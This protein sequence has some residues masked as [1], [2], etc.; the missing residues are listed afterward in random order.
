MALLIHR[1]ISWRRWHQT[2]GITACLGL[3]LWSV[4]GLSHPL[5][6]RVQPQPATFQPPPIQA[7]KLQHAARTPAE[8]L[9]QHGIEQVSHL[10]LVQW[11]DD[12]FFQVRPAGRPDLIYIHASSGALHPDGDQGYA[13]MLARHY[14]G[15][16][17][18]PVTDFARQHTFA[19]EYGIVNRLLPAYKISFDRPDNMRVY[20]HTPTSRLGTLVDDRKAMFDW[21]FRMLHKWAWLSPLEPLRVAVAMFFILAAFVTAITGLYMYYLGWRTR[22]FTNHR[23]PVW[24]RRIGLLVAIT[25]LTFSFSGGYHLLKMWQGGLGI[26]AQITTNIATDSLIVSPAE[27]I[28]ESSQSWRDINVMQVAGTAYYRFAG[29]HSANPHGH[30]HHDAS[31]VHG[32]GNASLK[33]IPHVAYLSATSSSH[34]END[35][36]RHHALELATQFSGLDRAHV[37]AMEVIT[38][39]GGEYGF[40]NKLLPVFRVEFDTRLQDRYYIEPASNTLAAHINN[41]DELE[42]W[43]FAYLHKWNFMDGLGTNI[44]DGLMALFA[45]GMAIVALFGL[46][47]YLGGKITL[48]N[49]DSKTCPTSS[50]LKRTTI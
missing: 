29:T 16:T 18:T 27:Y 28:T 41:S 34:A 5:M 36:D 4:S 23:L 7:D 47:M 2:L 35:I 12:V 24:H 22:S 10:R 14:L 39:F 37:T 19:G 15:D 33:A 3:L 11:H 13:S 17:D 46:L 26:P 20:V 48:C 42:G 43:T 49:D 40:V 25:T 32:N 6:V 1:A 44:R 30:H 8:L 50:R 31:H 21:S 45:L 38:A 9:A